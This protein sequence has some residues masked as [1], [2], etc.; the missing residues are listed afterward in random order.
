MRGSS[1]V[2]REDSLQALNR[3]VEFWSRAD[4]LP[5]PL[6]RAVIVLGHPLGLDFFFDDGN[7]VRPGAGLFFRHLP[8]V[9]HVTV[10]RMGGAVVHLLAADVREDPLCVAWILGDQSMHLGNWRCYA[11]LVGVVEGE[12]HAK[13]NAP[14]EARVSVGD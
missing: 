9:D 12:A 8:E 2:G 14:L 4:E 10:M 3:S 6:L 7:Q 13:D 11:L 5:P 1:A